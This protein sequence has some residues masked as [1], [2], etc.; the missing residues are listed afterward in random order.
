MDDLREDDDRLGRLLGWLRATP[1]EL[2]GLVVLLSGALV[3][4][5]A[6]WWQALA[7][8]DELPDVPPTTAGADPA[9]DLDG[10]G[11]RAEPPGDGT[12]APLDAGSTAEDATG[13][14]GGP[15]PGTNDA[16]TDE[17][18]VH[19]TGAVRDPGLVTLGAG[20]RVGDAL[21]ASGGERGEADLTLV[22]LARPLTDGEHVHVPEE[23][24]TPPPTGGEAGAA[25][26]PVG[27]GPVSIDVNTAGV[28]ELDELPG[29]GPAKGQAIVAHRDEHGPFAEPGDLR[30]VSGI[31]Q[32]TFE[33]L[34]GLVTT[35]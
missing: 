31:G 23:G 21:D 35:S 22:N 33:G 24:E 6:L 12:S 30:D 34:A 13:E 28:D 5:G 1:A 20:S 15:G 8:P 29:I 2:V 16:G 14:A 17:V 26:A 10:A 19:V 7:R 3:A 18:T 25:G 9:Q 4:T 11:V 32:A 27:S